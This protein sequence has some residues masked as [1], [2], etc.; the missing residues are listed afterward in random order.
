MQAIDL[1]SFLA[2]LGFTI[3]LGILISLAIVA[4]VKARWDAEDARRELQE[5]RRS[6]ANRYTV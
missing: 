1:P 4:V 5:L 3:G 6:S 2:L